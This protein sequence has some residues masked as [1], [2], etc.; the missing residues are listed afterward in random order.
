MARPSKINVNSIPFDVDFME[1]EQMVCI[2]G[3]F[4]V[5]GEI[6][7]LKLLFAV[8]QKGYFLEWSLYERAKMI[9]LLPGISPELLDQIMHRLLKWGFFDEFLFRSAQVLT[10]VDIQRKYFNAI[11]RRTGLNRQSFPYLLI[12]PDRPNDVS[13]YNNRVFVTKTGVSVD[14]NSEDVD[15]NSIHVIRNQQNCNN[16]PNE[17]VNGKEV[18]TS[19]NGV[20]ATKTGVSVYNNSDIGSNNGVFVDNNPNSVPKNNGFGDDVTKTGFLHTVT[21]VSVD[22]NPDFCRQKP[23]VVKNNN[24]DPAS[25]KGVSVDN[26]QI[27]VDNNSEN[28]SNEEDFDSNI[29]TNIIYNINNIHHQHQHLQHH[30]KSDQKVENGEQKGKEILQGL[31]SDLTNLQKDEIWIEGFCMNHRIQKVDLPELLQKFKIHCISEG[32]LNHRDLTDTKTHLGS[33]LRIY[34]N[35][36]KNISNGTEKGNR[37]QRTRPSENSQKPKNYH[38]PL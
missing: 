17:A 13:A 23:N 7:A 5:K 18:I 14:N 27:S 8:Y 30:K 19:K 3:E 31:E 37:A 9:R 29:P 11:R 24:S 20:S 35:Q 34:Q 16:N 25:R 22:N 26:N 4:G 38:I 21:G 28:V 36:Q 6:A 2:A 1:S 12:D 15:E 33:W 10:S 32:K